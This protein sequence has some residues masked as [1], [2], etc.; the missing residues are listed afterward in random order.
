MEPSKSRGKFT[1]V[2]GYKYNVKDD[3]LDI[4]QM[5]TKI[6]KEETEKQKREHRSKEVSAENYEAEKCSEFYLGIKSI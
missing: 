6:Q 5:V 4:S 1:H 3:L 2:E